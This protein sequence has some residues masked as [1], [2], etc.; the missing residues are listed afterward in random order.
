MTE[1]EELYRKGEVV[2]VEHVRRLGG[3]CVGVGG[4]VGGGGITACVEKKRM[5]FDFFGD[6]R[7]EFMYRLAGGLHTRADVETNLPL[8]HREQPAAETRGLSHP[9]PPEA[10]LRGKGNNATQVERSENRP[11]AK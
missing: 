4:G 1:Y 6:R 9:D 8:T 3:G 5:S 7:P 2:E 10:L 11:C